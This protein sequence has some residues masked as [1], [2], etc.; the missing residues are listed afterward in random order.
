MPA[1]KVFPKS[2]WEH[3]A[4]QLDALPDRPAGYRGLAVRE[5]IGDIVSNIRAA[6][7][8]G[9]SL[10]QIIELAKSSGIDISAGTL[11]LAM[12]S[13][14]RRAATPINTNRPKAVQ[15]SRAMPDRSTP[16]A[17][18]L[19]QPPASNQTDACA[20]TAE[21]P[22]AP[23]SKATSTASDTTAITARATFEVKP[24]TDDL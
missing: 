7:A 15:T 20:S 11:K 8:R 23:A 9:Y 24:D 14:G 19:A 3:F 10:E 12:R 13:A 21:A 1:P 2:N 17:R 6:Q 16:H 4:Q 18:Q 5:A 22:K